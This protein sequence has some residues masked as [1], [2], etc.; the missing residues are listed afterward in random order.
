MTQE[1]STPMSCP[2][3]TSFAEDFLARAS[4]SPDTERALTTL[5]ELFFSRLPEYLELKS[6]LLFFLKTYPACCRMTKAGPSPSYSGRFLAWGI[7]SSG[8][9]LTAKITES[10]SPEGGCSLSDILE[11]DAPEKY[12]LSSAQMEKL[13]YR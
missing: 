13:L 2:A 5:A 12:Y 10:P 9:C 3:S 6:P 11:K 8:K 7:M 1:T 4:A